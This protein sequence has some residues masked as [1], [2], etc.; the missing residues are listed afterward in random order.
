MNERRVWTFAIV[1]SSICWVIAVQQSRDMSGGMPMPG[2]WTM[3][4]GWMVMPGQSIAVAAAMFLS[5]WTVMMVAMMLPS[6]L[7]VV[8]LYRGLVRARSAVNV[9]V[10]PE[11]VLLAGYFAVWAAFGA[12]VFAI[13]VG[14]ATL[15]MSTGLSRFVPLV[16]GLALVLA[17]AYQM[18]PLK[19]ACLDHCRSPMSFL[20]AVWREGWLGA[21]RLG[22]HHAGYCTS[23]CWALM[24]V[25]VVTG[26][27]N[28]WIMMLIAGIIAFEKGWRHGRQLAYGA[29]IAIIAAGALQIVAALARQ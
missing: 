18:T 16:S 9:P 17:G 14:F 10:A 19:R 27:M 1:I 7:P 11:A 28:V 12:V 21:F 25:Q 13:G 8:L 3:S 6:V 24:V 5:M 20:G 23:C 22:V 2:G 26:V 29:G 4:R 15:T